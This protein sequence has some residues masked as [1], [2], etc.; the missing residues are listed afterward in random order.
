MSIYIPNEISLCTI[1]HANKDYSIKNLPVYLFIHIN[2]RCLP[3][4]VKQICS[5]VAKDWLKFQPKNSK[6]P[7][8]G[9][10]ITEKN[11]HQKFITMPFHDKTGELSKQYSRKPENMQ[12]CTFAYAKYEHVYFLSTQEFIQG[13]VGTAGARIHY[14]LC[15]SLP[16]PHSNECQVLATASRF[17]I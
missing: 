8:A 12:V 1:F 5:P 2:S 3:I 15:G 16:K 4:R 7:T 13:S 17:K 10:N 9:E 6:P 14:C 11:I